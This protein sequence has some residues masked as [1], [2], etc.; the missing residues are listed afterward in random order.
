[1]VLK[2]IITA[3]THNENLVANV[4][5][6]REERIIEAVLSVEDLV[7]LQFHRTR[8]YHS[9]TSARD[10]DI[11]ILIEKHALCGTDIAEIHRP[12]PVHVIVARFIDTITGNA[13]FALHVDAPHRVSEVSFI[14]DDGNDGDCIE[15]VGLN[16]A[17]G[18]RYT[19]QTAI[20]EEAEHEV[21]GLADGE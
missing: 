2:G 7:R 11:H 20:S 19:W 18:D 15:G 5:F 8:F 14:A 3:V 1:M 6:L 16:I 10:C 4:G 9:G 21:G 17:A 13:V 12:V